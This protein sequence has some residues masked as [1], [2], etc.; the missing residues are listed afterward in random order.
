MA[1]QLMKSSAKEFGTD[2][3]KVHV[4]I[5]PQNTSDPVVEHDGGVTSVV[6]SAAGKFTVTLN[7][8]YYKLKH[9][10]VSYRDE[11]DNAD[12]YA[13][14]GAVSNEATTSPITVVVKLKTATTNTDV[15]AGAGARDRAIYLE[16]EFEDVAL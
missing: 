14:L 2:L 3:K 16:L 10:N 6:R 1:S 7:D 5:Y 11:R 9:A 4:R 12:L 8:S 15:A 13:Q